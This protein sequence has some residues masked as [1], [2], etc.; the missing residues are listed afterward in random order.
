MLKG[1]LGLDSAD[2]PHTDRYGVLWLDRG[3]LYAEDGT[4]HFATAGHESLAPGDYALPFQMLTCLLLGPGTTVTHDALRL[5]AGH[6]TGLCVVGEGGVRFYASMP[7]GPD[8]SARARRHAT[9]WADEL[10][11]RRH[12]A[13]R[14]YAWRLG[15]VVPS[16]DIDVLRGIEGARVKKLYQLLAARH[17]VS[18]RGR[19]YDR[20]SPDDADLPNQA[21]NHAATAVYAC[22]KV[23]VAVT[24]AIPQLGFIHEESGHAFALDIADLYR[25]NVT[26]PLAFSAVRAH[27]SAPKETI[28]RHVRRIC[29]LEFRR[30][31][32]IGLMIERVKEVL[33]GDDG[34]GHT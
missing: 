21:I 14:M 6:G 31:Q 12:V 34:G 13:R 16:S 26:V 23:A 4:L 27:L 30:K 33:D 24:G 7:A 11:A 1:R 19:R 22:A 2:I 5:L 8:R 29:A 32:L 3:R 25:E 15:E 20:D 28:D 9:L 18:W 10:G 17:G